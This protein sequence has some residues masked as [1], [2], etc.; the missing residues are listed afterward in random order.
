MF[1]VGVGPRAGRP[2][3]ESSVLLL[4]A[5]ALGPAF[6]ADRDVGL[7]A[8]M[9]GFTWDGRTEA[10]LEVRARVGDQWTEWLEL[11]SS[12]TDQPDR[13]SPEYSDHAYAGPAWLGHDFRRVQVRVASGRVSNL[14]L[15][16]IDTED[17]AHG[18]GVL[19]TTAVEGLPQ[20]PFII[21]RQ[22]WQADE[23]WRTANAP[24][25][26]GQPHYASGVRFA[27]IHHT[28]NSNTYL[29]SD[30]AALVR[31][32][33]Q[34]HVF[35]NGWCDI[36][37]NF[38]VDRYGQIFEGRFGGMNK[39]VIGGHTGGFNSGSTG[40]SV[41]GNFETD[42]VPAATYDALRRLLVWKL[43]YHGVDPL[44][45][46][47]EIAGDSPSSRWP[48]GT[49]VVVDN[50]EGHRDTN[51][52]ACPGK[53]LYALIPQLRRDVAADISRQPDTRLV[54]DWDGDGHDTPAAFVAGA[55]YIRNDNSEGPVQL[56]ISFG[57]PGDVPICGD[58]N[59]DGVD[60]PGVFRR[61]AWYLRN[62]TTSGTADVTFSYGNPTDIPVV[63]DW[64]GLTG[65]SVGV[66]REAT[67]YLVDV[68]GAPI[69]SRVFLYGV[70]GDR[71]VVGD[72]DGK[73]GDGIGVVRGGGWYLRKTP[74][75]G[76]GQLTFGFGA[77]SDKPLSGDWNGDGAD[78][79]GVARGAYWYF[80]NATTSGVADVAFAF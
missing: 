35:S 68:N 71:P 16:A 72:W 34:F 15:H 12:N 51:T 5:R 76:V 74:T 45:T 31:G 37:Y 27:V 63:G 61:G 41:I 77:P 53:Y 20:P 28:V 60:T 22:Q 62:S 7:D 10:T 58:W 39:A 2:H 8:E 65:D 66:V 56:A 4:S 47:A 70:G 23:S 54:C 73:A 33:Y 52:T 75:T 69:A 30:S 3:V 21:S 11:E 80:R 1:V 43:A 78:G 50:V 29:P 64:D 24:A 55:W 6:Q 49:P 9:V 59:D 25:C 32:I 40:V 26:D 13:T 46:T 57:G 42:P 67:W 18:G 44:G 19:T 14:R 17:A 36:G 79:P 48:V 38:L